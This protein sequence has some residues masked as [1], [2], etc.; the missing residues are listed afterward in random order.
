MKEEESMKLEG[1]EQTVVSGLWDEQFLKR[2]LV[3]SSML[4]GPLCLII[5]TLNS[6]VT[7]V[8]TAIFKKKNCDFSHGMFPDYSET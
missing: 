8:H 6:R 4:T 2:R 1:K 5:F 3:D 7:G